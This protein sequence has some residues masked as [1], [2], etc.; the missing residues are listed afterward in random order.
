MGVA[1][2]GVGVGVAVAR[3]RRV[4][5]RHLL[6]FRDV[7]QAATAGYRPCRVCRPPALAG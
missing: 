4:S 3:A 6:T 5:D 7:A 2:L 1:G